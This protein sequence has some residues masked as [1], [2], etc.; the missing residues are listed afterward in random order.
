[1]RQPNEQPTAQQLAERAQR[2]FEARQQGPEA[3]K[4]AFDR[5]FPPETPELP[6]KATPTTRN[7]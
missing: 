5:E 6:T 2:L 1:M 7:S 3:Y 4:Q